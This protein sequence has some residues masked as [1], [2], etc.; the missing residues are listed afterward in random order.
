MSGCLDTAMLLLKV[1]FLEGI[2]RLAVIQVEVMVHHTQTQSRLHAHRS[3]ALS[4]LQV[5]E[6]AHGWHIALVGFL[7]GEGVGR[8]GDKKDECV[9][10]GQCI[11]DQG[12]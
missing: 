1:M 6:L 2:H 8:E 11:R 10:T 12:R 5:Q 3:P 4:L 9:Q 7:W